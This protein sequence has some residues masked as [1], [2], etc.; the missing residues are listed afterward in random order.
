MAGVALGIL[1]GGRP[2]LQQG[3]GGGRL[4]VG[5]HHPVMGLVGGHR[6]IDQ[7]GADQVEGL[8]FPGL[9]PPT[10]LDQLA[11]AEAQ[12][13]ATEAAASVDRRQLPIIANQD[14][15]GLRLL[16]V[17]EQ[18][19][20]LAGADHAGLIDHQH[21][22]G[23]QLLAA[24]L[25]V[26]QEPVAGGHLLEP[27]A[28]Q[29]HGRDPGRGR[30]QEPVAVQLPGMPG[31]PQGE[32]LAGPGPP[33]HQGDPVAALADI[34]HHRLLIWPGAGM[35]GQGL[36]DRLMGSPSRLLLGPAGGC[37]DQ[38]LF[39]GQEVGG[40]PAAFLQGPVGDHADR[41]LG[42]EPV[43]ELL[44]FC[45]S[46]PGQTS[47]QGDQDVG[48]GEGGRVLGQP[49]RTGQP[50]E[51]PAGRVRGHHRARVAVGCPTGRLPDEGVRVHPT[52]GCLGPPPSIQGVRGLVLFGLPGGM[53]GPLDQSRRPLSTIHH[54]P[55]ELGIN[56]AG[57][58][59]EP[60]DQI[61]GH[62]LELA[63][64]VAVRGRPL[65][66]ERPG[67]LALVGGPVDGVGGQP[68]PVQ[69]AAVQ[70]R[71]AAV[72]PL[73]PVGDDQMR[74]Q[75]RVALSGG[76][77]VEPDGQQPLAGH[78]L[79]TAV[80]T[81]GAQVSVQ[82]GDRL[83]QPG[84]MSG[85]HR[86]SNGRLPQAVEDG[87]ALGRPQDHIEGGHGVAAMRAA[88]Q[89]P[90]CGVAALEHGLELRQ[91]C[92]ALQAEGGGAGAVP[93]A[94]GLAVAGQILFVVGGQL[95]GVV[96]LP[97]HREL[98]DVGHHPAAASSRR[99]WRQRTH[100]WCIAPRMISGR[101]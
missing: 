82:V 39:D 38:P 96:L 10:I 85:Q 66:P 47:T 25:K 57:A 72:R 81:A 2:V 19:G 92:F 4:G 37:R 50:V 3:Q 80:A 65:H 14:H 45:P 30:G 78:V 91:R 11:G 59:G 44:Q 99:R 79:D 32:G 31:N 89:L 56:L 7:P 36:A 12:A 60:A 9:V 76:P 29:A 17:L 24:A 77:V 48:A 42:Q 52:L 68:M 55:L 6:V 18:A 20:E 62:P 83:G 16:G 84:M 90:S 34:P 95:A 53:H 21:R 49:V 75:E 35:G 5:G 64:A 94:W 51:Q 13:E 67:Q 97:A 58:L 100:P 71:P 23:V 87:D 69:A 46:G 8:A 63:V 73:D 26:A 15:L 101:E 22:A 27:L 98:G 1:V 74:M 93:A 54:Q 86:P 33:H 70:R 61:L 28:L 43:R 40:G 41:S 88:Q